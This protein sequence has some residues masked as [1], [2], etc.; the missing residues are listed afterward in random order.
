MSKNIAAPILLMFGIANTTSAN[1]S[2]LNNFEIVATS[3]IALVIFKE[4]ISRRLWG[5]ILLVVLAS[6]VLGFEG[7]GAFQLNRESRRGFAREFGS[8]EAT[9]QCRTLRSAGGSSQS[10]I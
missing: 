2:L 5:G 3:I 8:C 4:K 7:A 9:F 1:V 10:G 6:A